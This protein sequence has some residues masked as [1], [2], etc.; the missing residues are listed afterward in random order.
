MKS[1]M[2]NKDKI[3]ENEKE[4]FVSIETA[5]NPISIKDGYT[6]LEVELITGKTHQIRAH[7]SSKGHPLLGDEKYGDRKWNN[8]FSKYK[9]PKWQLLHS[10]R[11]EFPQME[12]EF[13]DISGCS[14]VAKEP[15]LYIKLK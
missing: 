9:I 14:F 6:Y 7:L 4:Q 11:V 2:K 15:E 3:N 12:D 13:S 10:Y 8:E 5:Y 1:F